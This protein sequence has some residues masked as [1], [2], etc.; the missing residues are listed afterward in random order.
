MRILEAL[1]ILEDATLECKLRSIDMPEVR[2]ALDLL[3]PLCRK[4]EW[5]VRQFRGDLQRPT[6]P[7]AMERRARGPQRVLP[8]S[9]SGI[10]RNVRWLLDRQIGRLG[11]RWYKTKDSIVFFRG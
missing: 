2:T 9:F 8:V 6:D 7:F 4:Q 11:G 3:E 10:Y 5:I 1:T